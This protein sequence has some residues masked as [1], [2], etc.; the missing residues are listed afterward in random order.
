MAFKKKEEKEVKKEVV[1]EV[2]KVKAVVGTQL[3]PDMPENKQRWA[4]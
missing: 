1:K 2:V 3:D 4:R